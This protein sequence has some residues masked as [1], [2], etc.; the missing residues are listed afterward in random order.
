MDNHLDNIWV[1][2]STAEDAGGETGWSVAN[3]RHYVNSRPPSGTWSKSSTDRLVIR[4]N[5]SRVGAVT[6]PGAPGALSTAA[7]GFGALNLT[8]TAPSDTVTGY[9]VHYT[10][11][12]PADDA[13]ASTTIAVAGWVAVARA[14][15]DTTTSQ[16]I[17]NLPAY[18]VRVRVRAV[19]EGV[20]GAW[21]FSSGTPRAAPPA[22]A[23]VILW[24][25]TLTVKWASGFYGCRNDVPGD[26]CSSASVLTDDDFTLGSDDWEM[27]RIFF[28]GTTI[29]MD[30]NRDA[31]T[32]LDGY[33]LCVDSTGW[34]I[35]DAS[36][37][38]N[39]RIALGEN[40][41]LRSVG[42]QVALSIAS[43]C[44]PL[45]RPAGLQVSPGAGSLSLRWTELRGEGTIVYDVHY[46]AASAD[47]V[48]DDAQVSGAGAAAGWR[49]VRRS[50]SGPWET[51]RHLHSGTRYRVRVRG[52]L[53][54][55]TRIG[56]AGH[57][58]T[59][60]YWA[61]ATGT[62]GGGGGTGGGG[63]GGGPG[64]SSDATLSA[65]ALSAG[66]ETVELV[67][68]FAPGTLGYTARVGYRIADLRL[69]PTVNHA[70]ARI[71][72]NGEAVASGQ[73]SATLPLAVGEN[74]L[75]VVVTAQNGTT[76]TYTVTVTR[77]PAPEVAF[78]PG[79][80]NT[81]GGLAWVVNRSASAGTVTVRGLRRRRRGAPRAEAHPRRGLWRGVQARRPRGGEPRQ[82]AHR[83]RCG[84]R[85]LAPGVRE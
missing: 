73:A 62:P 26:E 37:Q 84:R 5:G 54:D 74:V 72:V 83:H 43:V 65:L 70:G 7:S 64:L 50:T 56:D 77:A 38:F 68:P 85:G 17:D 57:T 47:A 69:V 35:S 51:I 31:R 59:P 45:Q 66:A 10:S 53:V 32:A 55:R 34:A 78:F 23:P 49:A 18:W 33:E 40:V 52:R 20:P 80:S 27:T 63:V 61:H 39:N 2:G 60:G 11:G 15:G 44:N 75:E 16:V 24:S 58:G 1:T 29:V 19:N 48:A 3:S 13:P 36:H 76:R 14:V 71:T 21:A 81:L 46:T 22:P 9:D 42:D 67:E 79:A 41:R 6:A 28:T 82:G 30:F 8:W 12:A 25:A 4:V